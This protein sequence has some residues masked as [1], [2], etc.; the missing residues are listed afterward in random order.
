M[1]A[2]L[3]KLKEAA[4]GSKGRGSLDNGTCAEEISP[5]QQK[6]PK[7]G[8]EAFDGI[9]GEFT[10]AVAPYSEADPV[11]I[12]LHTLIMSGCYIGANPH[13]LVEHQPHPARLNFIQVGKTS[14][15]RWQGIMVPGLPLALD[16]IWPLSS[17]A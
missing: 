2:H 12:L 11:G 17:K 9:A 5:S 16:Q 15:V 10:K 4:Y 7:M 6:W 14:S 1:S 3:E 13:A 8:D